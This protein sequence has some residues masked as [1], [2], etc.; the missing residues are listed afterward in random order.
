MAMA[1]LLDK[2]MALLPAAAEIVFSSPG[3]TIV[4]ID[5][6][7]LVLRRSPTRAEYDD[8]YAVPGCLFLAWD[9]EFYPV[10]LAQY[11]NEE[12]LA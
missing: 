6:Y 2:V 12:A 11:L 7:P 5:D 4:M 9:G 8:S 3:K 10:A 1:D